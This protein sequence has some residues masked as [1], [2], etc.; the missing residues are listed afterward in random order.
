MTRSLDEALSMLRDAMARKHALSVGLVGNCA[1]VLPE[2]VRREHRPGLADRSDQR[3]R[4]AERLHP[5][6][7]S[8]EEAARLRAADPKQYIDR[9]L[10]SM[11]THVRAMLDLQRTRRDHV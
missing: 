2:L 1:E 7:Y 4:S 3:A 11:A 9:A 10:D 6:G 5:A 8:V